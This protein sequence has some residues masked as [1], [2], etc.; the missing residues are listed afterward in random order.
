M[1]K[2]GKIKLPESREQIERSFNRRKHQYV[3]LIFCEDEKTEKAYFEEFLPLIPTGTIFLDVYG[4]GL[5]P[6][7]LVKF[8]IT[9]K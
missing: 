4:K 8:A 5:G 6:L 9:R 7:E 3:F 2:K 1:A